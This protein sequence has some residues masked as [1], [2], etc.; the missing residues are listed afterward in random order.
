MN[1]RT[2][3]IISG[4][5]EPANQL[6]ELVISILLLEMGCVADILNIGDF[7]HGFKCSLEYIRDVL[8]T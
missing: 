2:E 5:K 3:V 4:L 7:S 8:L 6:Q 1:Q